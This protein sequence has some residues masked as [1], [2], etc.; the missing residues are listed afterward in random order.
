MI[1]ARDL[2][3]ATGW[4]P[5]RYVEADRAP[6]VVRDYMT[7]PAETV[8]GDDEVLA[9]IDLLLDRRIG[10][11]PVVG[12]KGRLEGVLTVDDLVAELVRAC[13]AAEAIGEVD[14]VVA[15]CMSEAPFTID[16][17]T[18]V[19]D[20]VDACRTRDVLHLPVQSDGWFIGIVSDRDLRL[21]VG[22]GEH[23]RR[24]EEIM[25]TGLVTVGLESL[26]SDAA[27]LMQRRRVDSIP[28]TSG[29]RLVGLLTTTDV[30][31]HLREKLAPE[32]Q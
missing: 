32:G 8:A 2:L 29:G 19:R 3:E 10:C 5:D 16:S 22:R 14:A 4:N 27:E 23:E 12:A 9:A 1:S 7:L 26:I 6:K 11:L 15:A 17:R 28:V 30:L 21:H 13:A 25:S 24:L 18:T 20:A 31:L